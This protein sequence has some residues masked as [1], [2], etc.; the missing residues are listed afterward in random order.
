MRT[1][2][3]DR[4]LIRPMNSADFDDFY[5]Y[6]IDNTLSRMY[7]LPLDKGEDICYQIFCSFL[8]GNK[9]YALEHKADKKVIGHLIAVAPEFPDHTNS[10][11]ADKKGITLAFAVSPKYQRQGFMREA[12][13]CVF[14]DLFIRKNYD[15]IHCGYYDYNAPSM[16][17]QEQLGFRFYSSHTVR[18]GELK[19]IDNLLYKEHYTKS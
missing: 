3:T 11:L 1:L 15:Y 17:L 2:E 19:I 14:D 16:K 10:D 8:T 13:L 9:T 6:I 18:N 4:L 5:N 12:L 7:G